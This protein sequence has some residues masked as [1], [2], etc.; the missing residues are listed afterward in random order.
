MHPNSSNTS[1][2]RFFTWNIP[3]TRYDIYII[4]IP[5]F[6]PNLRI[7][8][9]SE[10]YIL[11]MNE[12]H[13]KIAQGFGGD[14]SENL[15]FTSQNVQLDW[16]AAVASA[17]SATLNYYTLLQ[18]FVTLVDLNVRQSSPLPELIAKDLFFTVAHRNERRYTGNGLVNISDA[19]NEVLAKRSLIPSP[20]PQ[21][22]QA[23]ASEQDKTTNSL[24]FK[25][26]TLR[27]FI[28]L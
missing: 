9:L 28:P 2:N 4:S 12:C 20:A 27:L 17:T 26:V 8:P 10:V 13:V 1:S 25:Y 23:P 18:V 16:K 7:V 11:A 21:L 3:N 24:S 22:L 6:V 5:P 15:T 14:P 19:G